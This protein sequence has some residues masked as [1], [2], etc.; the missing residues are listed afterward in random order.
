MANPFGEVGARG[1]GSPGE[2]M[3]AYARFARN[4]QV[5]TGYVATP[6]NDPPL[7]P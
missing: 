7:T 6:V 4:T 5:R 1:I 2:P 3:M